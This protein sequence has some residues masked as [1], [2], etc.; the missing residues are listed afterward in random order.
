MFLKVVMKRIDEPAVRCRFR[1]D[2]T[3]AVTCGHCLTKRQRQKPV[4]NSLPAQQ[5]IGDR[6]TVS[7]DG[8]HAGLFKGVEDFPAIKI[9]LSGSARTFKPP[10]PVPK[11]SCFF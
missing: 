10:P 8:R 9:G 5:E 6:N 1:A 7:A 4:G 11:T 2:K 3:V